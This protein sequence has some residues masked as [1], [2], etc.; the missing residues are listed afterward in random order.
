MNE[1]T[2]QR[3][4]EDDEVMQITQAPVPA[5]KRGR[6]RPPANRAAALTIKDDDDGA[7]AGDEAV[8]RP[9]PAVKRAA[10]NSTTAPSAAAAGPILPSSSAERVFKE[11]V[12]EK[13]TELDAAEKSSSS[14]TRVQ[15]SKEARTVPC[16]VVNVG[17]LMLGSLAADAKAT[18][19]PTSDVKKKKKKENQKEQ[20]T[21]VN[22]VTAEHVFAALAGAGFEHLVADCRASVFPDDSSGSE[23]A[24]GSSDDDDVFVGTR[25]GRE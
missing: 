24:G 21:T 15:L 5:A 2:E 7:A 20:R 1:P 6:G 22:S 23:H 9:K 16:R 13:L 12:L 10:K 18:G 14:S 17:A 8:I 3:G 25:R 19:A 11:A 4:D